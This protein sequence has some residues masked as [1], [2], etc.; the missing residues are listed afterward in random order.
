MPRFPEWSTVCSLP[1]S[2]GSRAGCQGPRSDGRKALKKLQEDGLKSLV[3]NRGYRQYL[4]IDGA[5]ASIDYASVIRD[6][7]RVK[8]V[9]LTLEGANYIIRTE[10]TGNAYEAFR[11]VGLRPPAQVQPVA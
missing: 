10:L 6:L 9:R 8:A 7:S 4:K 2:R 3:S 5:K 11:V 1:E